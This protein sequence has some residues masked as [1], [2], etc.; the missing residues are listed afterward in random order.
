VQAWSPDGVRQERT[1]WRCADISERHRR[2]GFN[3]PAVD[4]DF[5][6]VEYNHGKPVALIEYKERHAKEPVLLHPT[7]RALTALADGYSP[8]PLPFIV[9][10]YCAE[11]WWF[12]IIPVNVRAQEYFGHVAHTPIS[13]Q[14][15]VRGLYLLRKQSLTAAD[16]RAIAELN[17]IVPAVE[18]AA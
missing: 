6:M 8:A 3:C 11:D 2:W 17:N 16:E 12:R 4:L 10:F 5:V 7:Y 1:N 9:A 14:R 15:F 13:E 18:V